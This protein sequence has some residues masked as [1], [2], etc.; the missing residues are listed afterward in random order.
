MKKDEL[1]NY[2]GVSIPKGKRHYVFRTATSR[3]RIKQLEKLGDVKIDIVDLPKPMTKRFAAGYLKQINF[4][5]GNAHIMRAIDYSV[6]AGTR[7]W[8]Q[9]DIATYPAFEKNTD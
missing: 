1:V 5:A 4:H 8:A 7:R 2:A 3:D 6:G 9:Q